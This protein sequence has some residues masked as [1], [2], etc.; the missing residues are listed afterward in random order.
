MTDSEYSLESLLKF[1][2]GMADL[3]LMNRNTAMSRKLA[4]TKILG[5]LPRSETDDLRNI[6][7][8]KAFDLFKKNY[9]GELGE[10]TMEVY[11]SRL[12]TGLKDFLESKKAAKDMGID[13]FHWDSGPQT[14]EVTTTVRP[15]VKKLGGW[16]KPRGVVRQSIPRG[17]PFGAHLVIPVP[18]RDGVTVQ[19][20]DIPYD[21]TPQEAEKV[22]A[23]VR[24]Y[25]VERPEGI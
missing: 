24:A 6:K 21:L 4:A 11:F 17:E 9:E 7:I 25:A 14:T 19:I 3:E 8:D 13:L 12:K 18:I 1:F 22:A 2:D 16:V 15:D 20:F 5:S 23:V 10:T